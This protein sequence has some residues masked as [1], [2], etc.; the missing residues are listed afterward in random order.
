MSAENARTITKEWVRT[1]QRKLYYA[2]KKNTTRRFGILYD[3]V[4]RTDVLEE[5]WK[6]VSRKNSSGGVD[7][8]SIRWIKEHGVGKFMEEIR[9]ELERGEYKAANIRRVYIPKGD[10]RQRPLGIPTVKDRVVQMAVKLIIEPLYE[11][12]FLQCSYGFRPKRSPQ[13]A[14]KEVHKQVNYRKWIV[15]IDLKSYFDTIPHAQ[16]M[17]CVRKRVTDRR[18]LHLIGKWLKAGIL[19]EGKVRYV[20]SGSPQGGVL[21]PLLS[22]IYLHEF[23]RQWNE[24]YG[25]LVR[26]ADD[27]V[28][29]CRTQE[30]AKQA[31]R[32]ATATIEKLGL[33]LNQ[34]KT[35]ICHVR[36]GF[37]FLGFTYREGYS[38]IWKRSV[39]VKYPRKKTMKSIRQKIKEVIKSFPLGTEL[40]E[41]IAAINRK[42]RGWANYF[43]IGNAY[44][45]AISLNSYVCM[46]LR[47]F[48]RRRKQ[49]KD[50]SGTRKWPNAYFY[51]KGVCYVPNLL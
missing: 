38:A 33:E 6:R 23:D 18:I 20:V 48:W 43:R 36:E 3:K 40:K 12:D 2:A 30:A 26:Y 10:G 45:A 27:M 46:Q 15:D 21:S 35:K 39:R 4:K 11:A 13:Q 24:Q 51:E 1:F 42:L 14:V 16:L 7:E 49:R 5:A 37:D 44:A 31:L 29:L 17:E 41:V 19:E 32:I 50:I 34:E 9:E 25:K 28:I 8:K 22:N 47:I